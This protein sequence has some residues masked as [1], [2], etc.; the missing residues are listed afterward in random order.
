MWQ[1]EGSSCWS[2]IEKERGA[3]PY[4]ASTS[5]QERGGE[6]GEKECLGGAGSREV[7]RDLHREELFEKA[8]EEEK[9][10]ER[11]GGS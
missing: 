9:R 7:E 3:M 6:A 4:E 1:H 8:G 2:S 5:S 11:P 10:G